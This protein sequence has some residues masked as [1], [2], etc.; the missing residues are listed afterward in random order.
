MSMNRSLHALAATALLLVLSACGGGSKAG[1]SVFDTTCAAATDGAASSSSGTGT[2]ATSSAG[3]VVL[4]LS[5]DTISA[6]TPGTVTALVKNADGTPVA[7]TLVT[8]GVTN[9]TAA[10]LPVRVKTDA[11]GAASTTLTPSAS[12]LGADYVT[13]SADVGTSAATLSTRAVFTASSVTTQLTAVSAAPTSISAYGASVISVTVAGASSS[14]PV[15]VT[16]SSTCASAATPKAVLSPSSVTVTGSTATTTYQ[17][18]GCS[19][20]DRINA[21]INGTS[22]SRQV[23]LVVAAPAAQSLEFLAAQPSTIC[24]AGS[25]CPPVSQVSFVLRDQFGNPV[26]SQDVAFAL[27]VA[28]V[29]DLSFNSVKTDAAGVATVSVSARTLPT[30]V[31]VRATSGTLTTVSNAL[32]I[33]AGL[34]TQRGVSFSASVYNVDGLE[35]DGKESILRLQLNDRFGNAVPDGTAV[36]LVAEGASVIPA[37]CLTASGVCNV[38]LITSNYRPPNGRITVMAYAQGEESFDDGADGNNRYTVGEAFQDLGRVYIDRDENGAMDTGEYLVGADADT[39]WSDNVYVRLSRVFTLSS[40]AVA[41]RFF[42]ATA[43]GCSATPLAPLTF[44][45]AG[46]CRVQQAFCLR[47]SNAN[48]DALGGNPVPAGAALSVASKAVGASAQVDGTPVSST[49]IF[50]TRH[51]VTVDLNDCSQALTSAGTLDLTV[52]MPAGQKYTFPIGSILK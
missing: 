8:F 51:T 50:P 38:K 25:G 7:N 24:L 32:A 30:P 40:S 27:D 37:S 19:G 5:S 18:K 34:P 23:D 6:S 14:S 1:C 28:G 4:S 16:F 15:T 12:A 10:V 48:A 3:T 49:T 46:V 35:T 9:G 41:P 22:Q 43:N 42:E 13:A 26:A 45:M 52:T 2:V 44:T 39:V 11:Q 36:S 21:V 47:D 17:D 31:R 33:N 20:T 29:A